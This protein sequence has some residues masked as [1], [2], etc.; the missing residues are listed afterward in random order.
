MVLPVSPGAPAEDGLE[1]V[2]PISAKDGEDAE[3]KAES[4]TLLTMEGLDRGGIRRRLQVPEADQ[5][6]SSFRPT[7]SQPKNNCTRLS[8]VHQHQHSE[9]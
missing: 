6:G 9:R 3:R 4:P 5:A 8:D 2:E 1:I 7:P